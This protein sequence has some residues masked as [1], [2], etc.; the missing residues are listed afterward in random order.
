MPQW[1]NEPPEE[2]EAHAFRIMR[3]PAKKPICGIITSEELLGCPTHFCKNRTIPCEAPNPCT[4]CEEG[5]SWRWHGWVGLFNHVTME[6]LLFEMTAAASD[7]L[8]LYAKIHGTLRAC[9]I[10]AS[11]PSGRTNG[12][13][14]IEPR[15][16]DETRYRIPPELNVMKIL[17]HIWGVQYTDA[18]IVGGV[19]P[20]FRRIGLTDSENDG[21]HRRQTAK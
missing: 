4:W 1:T 5:F 15:Q 19:A 16:V 10:R 21:R 11:R 9:S 6:H 2:S 13:V 8:K 17:C 20:G 14:L 7:P 18:E 12:R 3:T